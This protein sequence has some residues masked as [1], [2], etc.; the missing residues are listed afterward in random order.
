MLQ[1]NETLRFSGGL[2]TLAV[3]V[4]NCPRGT[5][6]AGPL[7]WMVGQAAG[8][9]C[10]AQENK[11]RPMR[12]KIHATV[13]RIFW[14]YTTSRALRG[15][16]RQLRWCGMFQ[17]VPLLRSSVYR[18]SY[19]LDKRL[20]TIQYRLFGLQANYSIHFSSA[21]ENDHRRDT[22]DVKARGGCLI[23]VDV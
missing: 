11:P 19:C 20:Q 8:G 15:K 17:P 12:K 22:P 9:T 10:C 7:T 2:L 6:P 18:I 23:R 3:Y 5:I 16:K 4:A 13:F 14:Q 21:V 1:R